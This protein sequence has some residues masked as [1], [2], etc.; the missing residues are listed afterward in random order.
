MSYFV[1]LK[2][3]KGEEKTIWGL[4]LERAMKKSNTSVGDKIE[5]TNEGKKSVDV[6]S[7]IIK[8]NKI[9]GYEKKI[10]HKN[11]WSI[12]PL[13]QN[14]DVAINQQ[15]HPKTKTQRLSI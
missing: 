1:T 14:K 8:D 13:Y 2:N 7:P 11:E 12:K 3:K 15:D 9:E 5:L 10:A 4:D 6:N